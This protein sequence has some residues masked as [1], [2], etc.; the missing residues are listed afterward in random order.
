[1]KEKLI[2]NLSDEEVATLKRVL[3]DSDLIV[4]ATGHVYLKY[5]GEK[6]DPPVFYFDHYQAL[7]INKEK[8][9]IDPYMVYDRIRNIISN[10]R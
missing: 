1:M 3:K 8:F 6:L 4:E 5:C 2:E 10:L 9:T 7:L